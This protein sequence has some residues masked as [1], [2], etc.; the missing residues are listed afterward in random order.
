MSPG[1][2][3]GN[4]MSCMLYLFELILSCRW[5]CFCKTLLENKIVEV[6]M[7]GNRERIKA[8]GDLIY[9]FSSSGFCHLSMD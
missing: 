5:T 1:T 4:L 3:V 8:K 2:V 7:E 9:F 6:E